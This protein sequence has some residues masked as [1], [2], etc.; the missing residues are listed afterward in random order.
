MKFLISKNK[1]NNENTLLNELRKYLKS[2]GKQ[3]KNELEKQD[4]SF[5]LNLKE[6]DL[7]NNEKKNSNKNYI[8]YE[9]Q[10]LI[11]IHLTQIIQL[12]QLI[13]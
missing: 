2:F 4:I 11:M 13:I 9:Y 6:V 7:N 10:P 5:G 8:L 1:N 12:I 3:I